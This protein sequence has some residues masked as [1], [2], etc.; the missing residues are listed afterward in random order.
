MGNCC[1]LR[2]RNVVE[3]FRRDRPVV[4]ARD[5]AIDIVKGICIIL[6][7]AGHAMPFTGW[8]VSLLFIFRMPCFFIS[9]GFLFKERNLDTPAKYVKRK[10][11]GLWYPFVFWSFVYLLLH[12]F[13]AFLN[14]YHYT[15][16]G[17]DIVR[18]A[19]RY[20]LTAGTEQLLGGFWFLS[21]LLFATVVGYFYYKW[22][23]FSSKK[24]ILGIVGCL[25]IAEILCYFNIFKQTIHLNSRDFMATA[26]F[27]TG[28][29]YSRLDRELLSRCRWHIVVTAI[30][31]LALQTSF[32]P[33]SIGSLTV[34]SVV[35][36]YITSSLAAIAMIQVCSLAPDTKLFRGLAKVGVR[37][38]DVLVFHFLI[39]KIVSAV[40]LQC[41]GEPLS[42]LREFPVLS[43]NNPWL[44]IVYTAVAVALSYLLGQLLIKAKS[45][46][47][48]LSKIIP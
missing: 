28:T 30:V 29:L 2:D 12:N 22:I 19:L 46:S 25:V 18:L 16:T 20:F 48:L 15:Y 17:G 1:K 38:I 6:M 23:G 42:R 40:Y 36:F 44:W 35:P 13:F 11:K 34:T 21:S 9:S 45:K 8:F 33:V 32:M 26:Y 41:S 24:I 47:V 5:S 43:G 14:F 27:L 37:T 39:F 3:Y 7:V 31:F 4:G 10:V